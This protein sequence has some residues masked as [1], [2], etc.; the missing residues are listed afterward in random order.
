MDEI[1]KPVLNYEGIY[2]VSDLGRVRRIAP[3]SGARVGHILRP[4][5]SN[6]YL[7]VNLSRNGDA[8]THSVH[9][10]IC[11]AFHGRPA[12]YRGKDGVIRRM[13]TRHFD[14]N[15][16]NNRADNLCWGTISQNSSDKLVHGTHSRG[17][18]SARAKLTDDEVHA[19]RA[20]SRSLR[21]IAPDYGVSVNTIWFIK[22]R[23][24]WAW[25]PEEQSI[26]DVDSTSEG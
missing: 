15:K 25:L 10:L 1:W 24:R 16:S 5:D 14:G 9:T 12:R 2:V 3:N 4:G 22:H 17:M 26:S 21:A 19:I 8:R 6:G 23:M 11:R 7:V 13:E 18:R 20:D